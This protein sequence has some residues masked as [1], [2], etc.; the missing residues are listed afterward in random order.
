MPWVPS[1][2]QVSRE[3]EH[4]L[5]ATRSRLR[6]EFALAALKGILCGRHPD[7]EYTGKEVAFAAYSIADA[8][9][10]ARERKESSNG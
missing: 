2:E 8:M 9:L 4:A 1:A 10:Q 7:C 3:R 5:Q 6:D